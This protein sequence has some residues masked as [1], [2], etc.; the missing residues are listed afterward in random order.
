MSNEDTYLQQRYSV[1]VKNIYS[2]LCQDDDSINY[3]HIFTAVATDNINLILKLK[4][5]IAR[6]K[7]HE[8]PTV[9]IGNTVTEKRQAFKSAC[10]V[11]LKKKI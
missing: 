11:V 5:K 9:S 8:N 10:N 2:L 7:H 3:D 6:D 1:A 4:K